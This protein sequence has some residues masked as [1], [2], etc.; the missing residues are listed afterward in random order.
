LVELLQKHHIECYATRT[1]YTI[2]KVFTPIGDGG[3]DLFGNY[4]L[5]NY[6]MQVKNK[7]EKYHVGPSDIRE[8]SAVLSK[9]PEGTVG[10][11]VTNTK[12]SI[13]AQNEAQ[14]SKQ[15]IFL[16]TVDNVISQ[17]KLAK[18]KLKKEKESL[19]LEDL[20]IEGLE[21]DSHDEASNV[22]GMNLKGKIK[23]S[24]LSI[25]RSINYFNPY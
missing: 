24:K 7:G 6:I 15:K 14:N 23:I 1:D 10:F 13:N 18:L 12:Y 16:R 21:I 4:K 5:M 20:N 9:Q 11:F 25:N 2:N 3:I 8:F 19:V 17:I 22:F